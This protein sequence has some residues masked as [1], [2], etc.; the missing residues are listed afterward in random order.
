ME[1]QDMYFSW[2]LKHAQRLAE[3]L[4]GAAAA[5]QSMDDY[6]RSL[7]VEPDGR[8][9]TETLNETL[10]NHFLNGRVTNGRREHIY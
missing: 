5:L 7:K 8:F 3:Y 1:N 4:S 6:L 10:K 2:S 9:A